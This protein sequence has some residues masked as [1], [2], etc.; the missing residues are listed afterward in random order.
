MANQDGKQLRELL[1]TEGSVAFEHVWESSVRGAWAEIVYAYDGKYYGYDS[2]SEAMDGPYEQIEDAFTPVHLGVSSGTTGMWS[3]LPTAVLLR[4]IDL[5]WA[6]ENQEIEING[7]FYR[8]VAIRGPVTA[9]SIA[10][11][12]EEEARSLEGRASQMDPTR[13]FAGF[14]GRGAL[15]RQ[16]REFRAAAAQILRTEG[17]SPTAVLKALPS[18]TAV[19]TLLAKV[20]EHG[21]SPVAVPSVDLKVLER[22]G[23]EAAPCHAIDL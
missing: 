19:A 12:L 14:A 7:D 16:A 8:V 22:I 2:E 6:Q 4:L 11:A 23:T 18:S 5:T 1:Q 21:F 17:N 3:T 20:A 9:G 15:S 10:K 13:S